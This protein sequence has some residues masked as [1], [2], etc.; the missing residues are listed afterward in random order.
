MKH[1]L[2]LT[3]DNEK[4]QLLRFLL[5]SHVKL[6]EFGWEK[7]G[8]DMLRSGANAISGLVCDLDSISDAALLG[9][10]PGIT[11]PLLIHYQQD[12]PIL[13]Y[14]TGSHHPLLTVI[15]K[16]GF[17]VCHLLTEEL[18]SQLT[19]QCEWRQQV[20]NYEKALA[21]RK[22]VKTSPKDDWSV[23]LCKCSALFLS[24]L[25][26]IVDE[27]IP[28]RRNPLTLSDL[29]RNELQPGD[30]GVLL[31]T[32]SSGATGFLLQCLRQAASARTI[33]FHSPKIQQRYLTL[34]LVA[35]ETGIDRTRLSEGQ[36]FDREWPI[37]YNAL[38]KLSR[39]PVQLGCGELNGRKLNN[40]LTKTPKAEGCSGL[41][42]LDDFLD[43]LS[44]TPYDHPFLTQI[45]QSL[46]TL[47]QEH[48]ISIIAGIRVQSPTSCAD[49]FSQLQSEETILPPNSIAM[50]LSTDDTFL[51]L[52]V[53]APLHGWK[54]NIPLA[55]MPT[56]GIVE[57]ELY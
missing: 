10:W 53:R 33:W 22:T 6:L 56:L 16:A 48:A 36:I 5:K 23:S 54:V 24:R 21:K 12:F 57:S 40:L 44:I 30:V 11:N 31:N 2:H 45:L 41:L 4:H 17:S 8:L 42:I 37:I 26:E 14:S 52:L 15:R 28:W 19:L 38:E 32:G 55:H 51:E 47:A 13:T 18:E 39:L 25:E 35:A 49:A 7:Q 50:M 3:N 20:S 34:R 46:T 29:V 43:M 1:I 27:K 9:G